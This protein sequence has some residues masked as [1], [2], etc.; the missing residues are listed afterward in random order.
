MTSVTPSVTHSSF[1]CLQQPI[2]YP[3]SQQSFFKWDLQLCPLPWFLHL[4]NG[5]GLTLSIPFKI[6]WTSINSKYIQF[7]RCIVIAHSFSF[8]L[9]FAWLSIMWWPG[10]NT[11]FKLRSQQCSYLQPNA[12]E[13]TW[14]WDTGVFFSRNPA[15]VNSTDF[16]SRIWTERSSGDQVDKILFDRP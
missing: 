10:E 16:Q 11:G 4:I 7:P 13:L 12:L 15:S 2:F 3:V 6:L 14:L 1:P 8:W 9:L 5:L